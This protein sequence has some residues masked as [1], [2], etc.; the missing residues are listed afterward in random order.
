MGDNKM[1]IRK[2]KLK[3]LE[4]IDLI[5]VFGTF[6][7]EKLQN[8]NTSWKKW[9]RDMKN[10][11]KKRLENMRRGIRSKNEY[12]IVAEIDGNICGF[13][14]VAILNQEQAEI[15]KLYIDKNF[16]GRGIASKIEKELERWL[17]D[18]KIKKVYSRILLKNKPSLNFHTK[19]GFKQTAVRMDKKLK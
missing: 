3:D 11:K 1:K 2:A 5:Y 12:W 16:R 17:K 6:D 10:Y 15:E 19:K 7:E 9:E 18:K 14:Q 13:G 8:K 4:E